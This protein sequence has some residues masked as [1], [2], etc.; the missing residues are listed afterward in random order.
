MKTADPPLSPEK[1]K[2]GEGRPCEANAGA[3]RLESTEAML[4]F[5]GAC[6]VG[7]TTCGLLSHDE[8]PILVGNS[9]GCISL[10]GIA[11]TGAVADKRR[12][13]M[14]TRA[15]RKSPKRLES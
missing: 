9:L 1:D 10:F 15:G 14:H 2:G 13:S 7:I 11:V 8:L 6:A 12:W 5:L 3:D 4:Q